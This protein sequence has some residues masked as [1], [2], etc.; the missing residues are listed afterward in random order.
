MHFCWSTNINS[1]GYGRESLN[2]L[3]ETLFSSYLNYPDSDG[4]KK[5]HNKL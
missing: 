5:V 3:I 2:L 4:L 1:W